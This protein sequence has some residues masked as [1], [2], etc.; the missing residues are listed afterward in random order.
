MSLKKVWRFEA[1][2]SQSAEFETP[3]PAGG[4]WGGRCRCRHSGLL[5]PLRAPLRTGP[6]EHISVV[7]SEYG[8]DMNS[9]VPYLSACQGDK[10]ESTITSSD[11]EVSRGGRKERGVPS[12]IPRR[13]AFGKEDFHLKCLC[14]VMPA[15]PDA[16]SLAKG[17]R[18]QSSLFQRLENPSG[19]FGTPSLGRM[20][21]PGVEEC[22]TLA[23]SG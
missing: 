19:S 2:R 11:S 12:S 1:S 18:S 22:Q 14:F 16:F 4:L 23:P 17:W 13:T 8:I 7:C 10:T 5:L 21:S 3:S 15:C 9:F 6:V 20:R